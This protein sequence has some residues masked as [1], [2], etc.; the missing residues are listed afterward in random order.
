MATMMGRSLLVAELVPPG[1]GGSARAWCA[2]AVATVHLESLN[3]AKVR[4]AQLQTANR[5]LARYPNAVLCGDFNFGG[6]GFEHSSTMPRCHAT[7]PTTPTTPPR[8]SHH[9]PAP[10]A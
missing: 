2:G 6:R 7:T 9:H 4:D 5:A 8:T 10:V 3:S 1:G